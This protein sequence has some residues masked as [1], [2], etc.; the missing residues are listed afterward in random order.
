MSLTAPAWEHSRP[1]IEA[2]LATS[3]GL[4]TIEDV[5][6]HL[7]SGHY[8][9]WTRPNSAA[10]TEVSQYA[11]KRVLTVLHGGGDLTELLGEIEPAMCDYARANGCDAIMGTGRM[12]WRRVSEPKGY[13]FGFISMFKDL[14]VNA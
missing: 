8:L 11:R 3:P 9:L 2:A 1:L 7:A 12:G 13:R 6:R 5:E 4:E 10:I 14:K